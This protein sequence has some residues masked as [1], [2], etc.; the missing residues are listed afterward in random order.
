MSVLAMQPP[1][2]RQ[3]PAGRVGL[4]AAYR[5]FCARLTRGPDAVAL[6]LRLAEA[7]LA[8][9][10]DLTVWM[11]RPLDARLAD[12][13][14]CEAWP[15]ICFA[16]VTRPAALRRGSARSQETGRPGSLR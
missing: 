2:T 3:A 1:A 7:F 13:Q 5:A 15:L 10:P 9:H 8:A 12:L 14:R 11:T 6:R 4:L 16:V